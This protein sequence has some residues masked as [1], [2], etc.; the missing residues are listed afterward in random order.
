MTIKELNII[1]ESNIKNIKEL[2]KDKEWGLE[3]TKGMLLSCRLIKRMINKLD[4]KSLL[5]EKV[6]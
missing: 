2:E 4:D 1:L 6:K 5:K 3:F